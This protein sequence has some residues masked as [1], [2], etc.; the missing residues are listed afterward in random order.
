MFF[1]QFSLS[2]PGMAAV[3][4]VQARLGGEVCWPRGRP[5][6]VSAMLGVQGRDDLQSSREN[7]FSFCPYV[8]D[9]VLGVFLYVTFVVHIELC[10]AWT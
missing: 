8:R 2:G 10:Q 7:K 5:S 4:I 6:L 1:T 9:S 3:F